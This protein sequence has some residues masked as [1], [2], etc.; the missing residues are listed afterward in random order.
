MAPPEDVLEDL[1]LTDL[2]HLLCGVPILFLF[3]RFSV[4][5]IYTEEA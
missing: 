5:L 3:E 1:D 2:T 4:E